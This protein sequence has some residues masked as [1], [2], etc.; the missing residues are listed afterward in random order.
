MTSFDENFQ[1]IVVGVDESDAAKDAIRFA[2][3]VA[4]NHDA[5]LALVYVAVPSALVGLSAMAVDA[6]RQSWD[7][8]SADLQHVGHELLDPMSVRWTFVRREGDAAEQIAAVAAE[9]TADAVVVGRASHRVLHG[10]LGSVPVRLAH[11]APC[12]VIVVP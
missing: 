6:V 12:P 2:A 11:S 9:L 5:E 7:S 10:P 4:R 8:A 1:V 3:S